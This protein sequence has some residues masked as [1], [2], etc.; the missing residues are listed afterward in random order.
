MRS[1]D[2]IE[3]A[4]E[5][6][7]A[8]YWR[9]K[10]KVASYVKEHRK[11]PEVQEHLREYA[12][13]YNKKYRIVNRDDLSQERKEYYQQNK[14]IIKKK[15]S[16]RYKS[17]TDRSF[18]YNI[19]RGITKDQYATMCATQGGKCKIC[20]EVPSGRFKRLAVDHDHKSG[21]VRGLLCVRCNRALGW[22]KDDFGLL[23][24]AAQYL[25]AGDN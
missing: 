1:P 2:A 13:S 9:N 15:V 14:E 21:E 11:I 5:L 18:F 3:R 24:K 23:E 19:R 25:Q 20:G 4:R 16:D 17:N 12:K 8:Y 7:R 22:F 10:D 6:S